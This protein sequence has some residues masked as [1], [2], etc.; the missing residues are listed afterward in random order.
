MIS[1][2]KPDCTYAKGSYALANTGLSFSSDGTV[3]RDA[4]AALK[5]AQPNTRVML[6]VGGATYT[7]F[8][9]AAGDAAFSGCSVPAA[10]AASPSTVRPLIHE[11]LPGF[12]TRSRAHPRPAPAPP[13]GLNPQCI[14][15][16]VTDFGLDG[17]DLDWEPSAPACTASGG[18]VSCP[19]DAEGVAAATKLRDALPKGQFLLST[20]S[21]HVGCYG[22]GAFAASKPASAYTGINLAM[23][24]SA[25]G[26]SFDLVNVMSY[27][28]GNLATT[29]FDPKESLRA[30]RAAWPSAAVALGV[31]GRPGRGGGGDPGR[32]GRRCVRARLAP[33]PFHLP[34]P[35]RAPLAASPPP[36]LAPSTPQQPA[37][38]P[39]AARGVGRQR[40]DAP[41]GRR[42][43]RLH[44]GQRRQRDHDLV[45]TQEG[46]A[47]RAGHPYARVRRPGRRQLRRAAADVMRWALLAARTPAFLA[48]PTPRRPPALPPHRAART[49]RHTAFATRHAGAAAQ[50]SAAAPA[51]RSPIDA[52]HVRAAARARPACARTPPARAAT[53]MNDCA[54]ARGPPPPPAAR[55]RGAGSG[56]PPPSHCRPTAGFWFPPRLPL[57][58]PS[59]LPPHL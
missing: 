30:H 18:R 7:N 57:P 4:V 31:E 53:R 9:G 52:A 28:A 2:A 59:L 14:K 10:A 55:A 11:S 48:P 19:T 51:G 3:V 56:A 39:G 23:A 17:A 26:Q 1:F 58:T 24:R 43:R 41:A 20:A 42:P 47:Q 45:A 22:E 34:R 54:P 12:P 50:F 25:A 27:D 49:P 6:A 44:Q 29:G 16:I 13:P 8:A 38:A 15:D 5:R 37:P 40:G 33:H 36:L 32:V 46:H 21:F 35:C